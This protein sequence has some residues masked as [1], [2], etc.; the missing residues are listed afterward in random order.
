MILIIDD[1]LDV[2]RVLRALFEKSGEPAAWLTDPLA[3]AETARLLRP[4]AVVCDLSMPDLDGL[5][6]VAALRAEPDPAIA[7]VPI[8]M[9]TALTDPALR[10]AAE[11]AGATDYVPKSAPFADL[12]AHVLQFKCTAQDAGAPASMDGHPPSASAG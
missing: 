5:G 2:C 9:Y 12:R 10:Q 8:V 11:A 1:N 4:D 7:G 6:V 3:A